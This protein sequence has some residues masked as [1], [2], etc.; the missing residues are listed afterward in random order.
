[1]NDQMLTSSPR[2]S[3]EDIARALQQPLPTPEQSEIISADLSPRLVIAGAGSGKTATMVDRVVW[4]VVNGVVR[5]DEVLGVTFT[6]KAAAELRHRMIHRLAALREAG[7][8]EPVADADEPTLD[9][10]ISTYHSYAKS[11]VSDYGLRIGI[12]KDAAQLGPSQCFQL[13]AQI[14]EHWEGELPTT[15]P[16]ASTLVKAVI[17][18]S[19]ECAE[20]LK[21]PAEVEA[22]CEESLTVLREMPN[23]HPKQ[24]KKEEKLRGTLVE[25]L[26]QK[27]L[28]ARLTE[29]YR[30]VKEAMQVMDF[31]DLLAYAATMARGVDKLGEEQS[32]MYRVVLLDEFQ[33]TSHA[34]MVLFSSIFGGGHSVMAVG[35]PKQSIYG[36]RGAS[37][38]QLFDFYRYFP[39]DTPDPSYLSVA[40]RNGARI[41]EAANDIA[42]PLSE[43]P[44]WVRSAQGSAVPR[45]RPRPDAPDGR[46]LAGVWET[47]QA[48]AEAI[49][50]K[51]KEHRDDAV[52]VGEGLPTV[53]VLCR[54]RRHMETVRLECE[55]Q[56][57]PYH[58][59]GL[60]GLVE[61]PEI[62]DMLA[63]LRVLSDPS[64]SDALMRL[65]AG[66]RWRIG[67][68]D[69]MALHDWARFLARRR[70]RAVRL[71][72]QEDLSTPEG[73]VDGEE[74]LAGPDVSKSAST[75]AKE[76]LEELLKAGREASD[77]SSLI[78]ALETLPAEGW[79][80]RAGRSL[81]SE[82]RE[83]LGRLHRE[84]EELRGFLGE[85]LTSLL[86]HIE[87]VTMLDLELTSKP[88]AD[89]HEARAN[90]DAF[91]EAVAEYCSTAPR[92]AASLDAS[93]HARVESG[94]DE[95]V[96]P[97]TQEHRY[98]VTSS[99]TGVTAFLA[100]LEAAI[101]EEG[102]LPLPVGVADPTAV[103]IVTVH[104]S[105]G[106]EWDEVY[107]QGMVEG[108]FPS[109]T[110]DAWYSDPG[111]LPWELRGDSEHLPVLDLR[112][113]STQE[114]ETSGLTFSEQNLERTIG[115]ERR[116][117]YV[118]V[119]RARNVVMLS[120]SWWGRAK[121]KPF[122]TSRF[123]VE[124]TGEAASPGIRAEWLSEAPKPEGGDANPQS[125]RIFA[126]LWPWDPLTR[127]YVS[128]WESEEDLNA[129][130]MTADHGENILDPGPVASRRDE[131]QR[132][133]D[134]VLE[135]LTGTGEA[136]ALP[137]E[138]TSEDMKQA[139]D[140]EEETN[141]LLAM[142]RAREQP[143]PE[144][145]VPK[146]VSASLLVGLSQ[147]PDRVL[148]QL[149]RPM[150]R[151]P[152]A[153]ARSGT[154][155][156]EWVEEYYGSTGMLD[157]GE[158]ESEELDPV[159]SDVE[160]LKAR[161]RESPWHDRQPWAVE[162][163][164]ETPVGGFTV[165]GRIDAVFRYDDELGETRW[166]LV[167]WKT[168]KV[169][170]GVEL[171]HK[172]V[173]LAVY[174][175]GFSKLHDIDLDH[176]SASFFY[177]AHG[178]TVVPPH[179]SGEDDLV[180]ILDRLKR[181]ER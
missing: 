60:G 72:I 35:D 179:I 22:Y 146:H 97:D 33:D 9:P 59:V 34:Q 13:A 1:M 165:R 83:R 134:R 65:L 99:A 75:E 74:D 19:G 6:K 128:E 58:V 20:H 47:D 64:R 167:D 176:V 21:T 78:E 37:E 181:P 166:E 80:S 56:G 137:D 138:A 94:S 55:R 14:V 57:I 152:E 90:L 172:S 114:L 159:D 44:E 69:A 124:I 24:L 112:A 157:L 86:H 174:R 61:T 70:E 122:E 32:D 170:H 48:E 151:R 7:L 54:A 51:I 117:A 163:P 173:Q 148:E 178:K 127:P 154:R 53:A 109:H 89:H 169:P 142:Y 2:Y 96:M 30:R 125:G 42:Q 40:W 92:L 177:V 175:L 68:Q 26:E 111:A 77:G 23:T 95:L 101:A 156:H 18:L 132:A 110:A 130:T 158:V 87:R 144:L 71:G 108:G 149:E 29:R 104:G 36:F 52:R 85:D 105:K 8:Y 27:L 161:F 145:V 164:L 141:L 15:I 82:A 5:P 63:I 49:V 140:W 153:T 4:L 168:G 3:P 67:P 162:Y 135:H 31:G 155:F 147:D 50:S 93:A 66:A 103:N 118:A 120:S 91:Y 139:E 16:A 76:R 171:E 123:L 107:L 160:E 102:G 43:R 113:R 62:T 88:G 79:T 81:S 39:S 28:V 100:W 116:L 150:P 98:T 121:A 11:I 119:T 143:Q 180:R 129:M 10:T 84:L 131:V 12:E 38:G 46:V 17:K 136:K 115:E 41:L 45:L 73:L 133:A 25:K 126:A 106:L